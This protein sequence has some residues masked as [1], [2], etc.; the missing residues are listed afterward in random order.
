MSNVEASLSSKL[1]LSWFFLISE[2][3]RLFGEL[4]NEI[5]YIFY[6]FNHKKKEGI[7]NL[8]KNHSVQRTF[9][10]PDR[11]KKVCGQTRSTYE[12]IFFNFPENGSSRKDS[13]AIRVISSL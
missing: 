11:D 12:Q 7:L 10:R 8:L 3:R 6:S 13:S 5:D 2:I 1:S 4:T 9:L